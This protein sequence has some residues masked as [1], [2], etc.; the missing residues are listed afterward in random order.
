MHHPGAGNYRLAPLPEP[1]ACAE[2]GKH[3]QRYVPIDDLRFGWAQRGI[4][5]YSAVGQ[6]I[7]QRLIAEP[8]TEFRGGARVQRS[9]GVAVTKHGQ[10]MA[11]Q[12]MGWDY[13]P[14]SHGHG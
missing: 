9:R 14:Q 3:E 2:Q 8:A 7:P 6:P 5:F 10:P 4:D 12:G 13:H 11:D 1:K